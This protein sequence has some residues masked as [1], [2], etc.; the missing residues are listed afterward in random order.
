MGRERSLSR[1]PLLLISISL[2]SSFR[3]YHPL[4]LFLSLSPHAAIM[5]RVSGPGD[6]HRADDAGF[7]QGQ[8]GELP[9]R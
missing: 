6:L 7:A 2:S 8:R 1:S 4:R 5:D 3:L 9:S